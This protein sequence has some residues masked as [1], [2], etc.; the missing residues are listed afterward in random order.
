MRNPVPGRKLRSLYHQLVS[1][2]ERHHIPEQDAEELANDTLL[3]VADRFD[4]SRGRIETFSRTV[5]MNKIRNFVRDRKIPPL[6][7]DNDEFYIEYENPELLLTRREDVRMTKLIRERL[8][9]RLDAAEAEFLRHYEIVLDELGGRAVSETARRLNLTPQEGHNII[10]RIERKAMSILRKP[11]PVRAVPPPDAEHAAADSEKPAFLRAII[12]E[13]V[14]LHETAAIRSA[15]REPRYELASRL[16][17]A[18]IGA[19]NRGLE[20][21]LASLAPERREKLF[22]LL[23]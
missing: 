20:K 5:L 10:Q 22:L 7:P 9:S 12:D 15:G 13:M 14:V 18:G 23:P 8:L 21:F 1:E 4:E 19:T 3:V 16:A 2:A 11:P 17:R 6:L